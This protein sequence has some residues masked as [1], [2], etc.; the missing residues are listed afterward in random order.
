MSAPLRT[1]DLGKVNLVIGSFSIT[2]FG[3]GDAVTIEP[4]EAVGE[5]THGA[6]GHAT[7][8]RSNVRTH[9]VTISLMATSKAYK[10]LMSLY[11][12]QRLE[13][14]IEELAFLMEDE[15][16]GDLVRSRYFVFTDVPGITK[17]KTVS[18]V[19]IKGVINNPTIKYG[20][21]L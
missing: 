5:V 21:S 6:D 19:E 16:T 7:F 18:G 12:V 9:T 20:D 1:Y 17:A 8:S 3:D 15:I 10:N 4:I 13:A 2:G 14:P 11:E